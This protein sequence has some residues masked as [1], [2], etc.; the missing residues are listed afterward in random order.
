L[1]VRITTTCENL[2]LFSAA[3]LA[4]AIGGGV[5]GLGANRTLTVKHQ[6]NI[7]GMANITITINDG[8]NQNPYTF[9]ESGKVLT[10]TLSKSLTN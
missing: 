4:L 1:G 6:A 9:K 10:Y 5:S 7:T 3:D 2:N 8:T